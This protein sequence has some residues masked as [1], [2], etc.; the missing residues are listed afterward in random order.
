MKKN[1]KIKINIIPKNIANVARKMIVDE[2]LAPRL[3]LK[4]LTLL[5][6][7][8]NTYLLQISNSTA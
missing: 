5:Q 7:T 4:H 8:L 3:H 2:Y 1:I 6:D